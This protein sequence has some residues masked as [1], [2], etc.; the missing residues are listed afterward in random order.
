MGLLEH[1]CRFSV[2]QEVWVSLLLVACVKPV[3]E[4][5]VNGRGRYRNMSATSRTVCY[6]VTMYMY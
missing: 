2:I 5:R 6:M 3:I 1:L 4:S